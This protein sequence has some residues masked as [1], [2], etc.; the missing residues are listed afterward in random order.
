MKVHIVCPAPPGSRRGNRVTAER[1]RRLLANEAHEVTIAADWRGQECD[2]LLAMHARKS[3][4]AI[5]AYRRERP[6]GSLIVALTGTDL[7]HDLPRSEHA[8]QSVR[9]A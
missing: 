9:W 8:R 4:P 3:Y 1:W 2:V 5:R 7:Y 6:H